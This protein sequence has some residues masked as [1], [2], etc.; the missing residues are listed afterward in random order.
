MEVWR[1]GDTHDV[2]GAVPYKYEHTS[3]NEIW[4]GHLLVGIQLCIRTS[5]VSSMM[6][7]CAL[8]RGLLQTLGPWQDVPTTQT[9]CGFLGLT[10]ARAEA[11][12]LTRLVVPKCARAQRIPKG[13]ATVL[14]HEQVEVLYVE[15]QRNSNA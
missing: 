5:P 4:H 2:D 11:L 9:T 8:L 12:R 13:L 3:V 10:L 1:Y 15:V 14:F 6:T 7:R